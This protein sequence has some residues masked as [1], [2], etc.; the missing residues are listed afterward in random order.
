M[1]EEHK[2][3]MFDKLLGKAEEQLEKF[4]DNPEQVQKARTKADQL[5]SKYVDPNTADQITG[6]AENLLNR[7]AHRNE[8]SE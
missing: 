6:G 1:S 4:A 3:G 7:A 5:L 8:P 2:G